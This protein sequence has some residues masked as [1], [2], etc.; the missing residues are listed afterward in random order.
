MNHIKLILATSIALLATITKANTWD[1][2]SDFSSNSNPNGAWTY[3]YYLLPG[4]MGRDL[5]PESHTFVQLTS[6]ETGTNH[7]SWFTP[8]EISTLSIIWQ[9][10]QGNLALIAGFASYAAFYAPVVRWTA[11]ANSAYSINA[12][13]TY[14]G[15][16]AANFGT[17]QA[18]LR[19][20]NTTLA[21]TY[22][23]GPDGNLH[24]EQTINLSAGQHLD[25]FVAKG[26]HSIGLDSTISAVPEPSTYLLFIVGAIA[27]RRRLLK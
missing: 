13:F 8:P 11:P 10:D 17:S 20:E 27:F 1:A 7:S 23:G 18:G 22:I 3:G 6:S 14:S 16:G 4:T 5:P 24:I 19:V 9:K 26:Q 21:Y 12:D 2:A 15:L 25:F